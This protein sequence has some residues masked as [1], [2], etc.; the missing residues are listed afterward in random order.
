MRVMDGDAE[1]ADEAFQLEGIHG[2][3]LDLAIWLPG[4]E[5][6]LD[7]FEEVAISEGGVIV[8]PV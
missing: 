1:V 3:N 7:A 4:R 8:P 5:R 6:V 2:D